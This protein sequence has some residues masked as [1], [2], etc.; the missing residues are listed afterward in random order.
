MSQNPA[1]GRR[2]NGLVSYLDEWARRYPKAQARIERHRVKTGAA[3]HRAH[4]AKAA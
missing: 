2:S 4:Y 1:A 3:K